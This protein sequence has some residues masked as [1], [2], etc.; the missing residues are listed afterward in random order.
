M[1]QNLNCH[2][3]LSIKKAGYCHFIHTKSSF[4]HLLSSPSFQP[5]CLNSMWNLIS[6]LSL[7]YFCC[8][9]GYDV[10]AA[11]GSGLPA[12]PPRGSSWPEAPEYPGHQWRTDQTGWLW[13]SPHLQLPDGTHLCGELCLFISAKTAGLIQQFLTTEGLKANTP[14]VGHRMCLTGPETQIDLDKGISHLIYWFVTE[15][16]HIKLYGPYP[17]LICS[18]SRKW[19]IK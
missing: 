11:P 13:F 15:H 10:P 6:S 4:I 3:D 8:L 7:C 1:Y 14:K 17:I 5:H 9:A 18:P 12:L 19:E 16:K 2:K